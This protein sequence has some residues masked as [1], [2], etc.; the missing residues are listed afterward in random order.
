MSNSL[1]LWYFAPAFAEDD[2]RRIRDL[3]NRIRETH[4]IQFREIDSKGR[5]RQEE[6]YKEHFAPVAVARPLSA[7]MGQRVE[8]AL[9]LKEGAV[10]LRGI[11]AVARDGVI[12]WYAEHVEAPRFLERVVSEGSGVI[13]EIEARTG[14]YADLETMLLDKFIAD[15][16]VTGEY[17]RQEPLGRSFLERGE[18]ANL[19]HADAVCVTEDSVDWAFEVEA[20]LNYTALGQAL[21][22]KHL[23]ELDN[24]GRNAQAGIICSGAPADILA[25]AQS[26]NVEVFIVP[27]PVSAAGRT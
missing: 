1:E 16:T 3:L 10:Y 23:Y 19:R 20:E 18:I 25:V 21:V 27:W 9:K 22:Y 2:D 26:L 6:L 12:Q 7:R 13:G 4:G 17:R 5:E 15:R 24:P 11:V 14:S 8:E